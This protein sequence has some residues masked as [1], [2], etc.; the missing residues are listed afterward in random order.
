MA[1]SVEACPEQVYFDISYTSSPFSQKRVAY[2]NGSATSVKGL[3]LLQS[4]NLVFCV[5]EIEVEQQVQTCDNITR[6]DT[7]EFLRAFDHILE[8][9]PLVMSLH[10]GQQRRNWLLAKNRIQFWV[11]QNF[12]KYRKLVINGE[13]RHPE[14]RLELE[15]SL[16]HSIPKLLKSLIKLDETFGTIIATSIDVCSRFD[17]PHSLLHNVPI[18]SSRKFVNL[19]SV[20]QR[21]TQSRAISCDDPELVKLT[22]K[23]KLL[24]YY[25]HHL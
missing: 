1:E 12:V 25:F 14:A 13:I 10:Q 4:W 7:H 18:W 19:L 17:W 5:N 16:S 20:I 15:Q 3:K 2:I 6:A 21:S 22:E 8:L 11:A 24:K 23:F 9:A